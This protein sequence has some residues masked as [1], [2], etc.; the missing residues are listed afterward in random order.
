MYMDIQLI[1]IDILFNIPN[2]FLALADAFGE[3][4]HLLIKVTIIKQLVQICQILGVCLTRGPKNTCQ[5]ICCP[6][7]GFSQIIHTKHAAKQ[8]DHIDHGH[9][10]KKN[11]IIDQY[12]GCSL[13]NVD[14]HPGCSC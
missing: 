8:C 6:V 1:I 7:K 4:P 9:C 2:A 11:K 13:C 3:I 12:A 5:L 10:T 14:G